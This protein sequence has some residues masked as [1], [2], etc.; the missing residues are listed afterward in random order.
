MWGYGDFN[1]GGFLLFLVVI[2]MFIGGCTV[3]VCMKFCP[4]VDV[5]IT[6]SIN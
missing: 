1:M 5:K 4:D 3:G 2:G 6:W